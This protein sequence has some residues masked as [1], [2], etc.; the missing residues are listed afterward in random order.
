M[1]LLDGLERTV[2][3]LSRKDLTKFLPPRG[4]PSED[5]GTTREGESTAAHRALLQRKAP[6]RKTEPWE[7]MPRA[8]RKGKPSQMTNAQIA[9]CISPARDRLSPRDFHRA[10]ERLQNA[11][12]NAWVATYRPGRAARPKK[13]LSEERLA[14]L[15]NA[16]DLMDADGSGAIDFAELAAAMR[17]LGFSGDEIRNTIKQ[18]DADGDGMLNFNEFVHLIEATT[19]RRSSTDVGAE[20]D[21]FPFALVADSIR[22]SRL[23]DGYSPV[24]RDQRPPP[25]SESKGDC[26]RQSTL[27]PSLPALA[28][29]RPQPQADVQTSPRRPATEA[30]Y[31]RANTAPPARRLRPPSTPRSMP[32]SRASSPE[33]VLP[34]R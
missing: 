2:E 34:S 25:Q 26:Q 13:D 9:D 20:G 1:V 29:S 14:G 3:H 18:G 16:F 33:V 5:G 4:V 31:G 22:I 11:Q 10:K 32:R 30:A 28:A 19:S 21:S 17:A 24:N 27:S 15:Q 6:P 7:R 23:I 8:W 12:I